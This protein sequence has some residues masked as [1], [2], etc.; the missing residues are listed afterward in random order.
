VHHEQAKLSTWRC[1]QFQGRCSSIMPAGGSGD[2]RSPLRSEHR[3]R[4]RLR[5]STAAATPR[6]MFGVLV[7]ETGQTICHPDASPRPIGVTSRGS[8]DMFAN[9]IAP[10]VARW[11]YHRRGLLDIL[12]E[13]GGAGGADL[14]HNKSCTSPRISE[15]SLL[16]YRGNLRYESEP[17]CQALRQQAPQESRQHEIW[18]TIAFVAIRI[19]AARS[20]RQGPTVETSR[21]S[22][23]LY[24]I[25]H[26]NHGRANES[27]TTTAFRVAAH[28]C[29]AVWRRRPNQPMPFCAALIKGSRGTAARQ[30]SAMC[31][32]DLKVQL[33]DPGRR[34]F[35]FLEKTLKDRKVTLPPRSSAVCCFRNLQPPDA[36][37]ICEHR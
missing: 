1:R 9:E 2:P 30:Q 27:S 23:S 24:C 34:A 16:S 3:H 18:W 22:N 36:S 11:N 8:G 37:S 5:R 4:K 7:P 21:C 15:Q 26:F 29:I 25:L 28:R 20:V 6:G 19:F 33:R 12:G 14:L 31:R 13:S 10:H 17:L 32:G 35:Q